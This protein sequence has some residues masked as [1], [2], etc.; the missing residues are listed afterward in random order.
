MFYV[1]VLRSISHPEQTYI[2]FTEDL[3]IRLAC[4]NKS[5]A[6]LLGWQSGP[7]PHSVFSSNFP[8]LKPG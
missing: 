7:K 6:V 3:R 5:S 8:R 4:H 1:Y 2:G